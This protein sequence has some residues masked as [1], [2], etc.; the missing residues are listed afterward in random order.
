MKN[1]MISPTSNH[2][3]VR[4]NRSFNNINNAEGGKRQRKKIK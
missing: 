2:E 1:L 3:M 4:K